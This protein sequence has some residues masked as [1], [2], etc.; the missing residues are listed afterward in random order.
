MHK[1]ST[2]RIVPVALTA[3]ALAL[4]PAAVGSAAAE[5]VTSVQ[6][7][8]VTGGLDAFKGAPDQA[9]K[10]PD[11]LRQ[12]ITS[13]ISDKLA[14]S[15]HEVKVKITSETLPATPNA[16][17]PGAKAELSG[18]VFVI[19]P[20]KTDSSAISHQDKSNPPA[21]NVLKVFKLTVT[22][23]ANHGVQPAGTDVILIPPENGDYQAAL[24]KSFADFVAQQI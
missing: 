11:M 18:T 3:L 12:A 9:T 7:I 14:A 6:N 19:D 21:D 17:G 10:L 15:G 22:S 24:V 4:G 16:T 1:H 20:A 23:V 5:S 8:E 13:R 2:S